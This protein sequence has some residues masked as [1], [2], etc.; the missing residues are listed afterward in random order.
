MKTI[1]GYLYKVWP[2]PAPSSPWK[3]CDEFFW[4]SY[5]RTKPAF[6]N[7][8][9]AFYAAYITTSEAEIGRRHPNKNL[10]TLLYVTNVPYT[11]I[12][13]LLRGSLVVYAA[14]HKPLSFFYVLDDVQEWL[15]CPLH[16]KDGLKRRSFELIVVCCILIISSRE[17]YFVNLHDISIS[18]RKSCNT[19]RAKQW[20]L[21]YD[22]ETALSKSV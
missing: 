17:F 13:A 14:K 21:L 7:C 16:I 10:D 22:N 12:Q 19:V 9:E 5:C 2:H 11:V 6:C 1:F 20:A 3:A 8:L 18:H 4:R 15:S